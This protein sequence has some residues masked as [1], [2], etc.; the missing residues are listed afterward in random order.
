MAKW[1]RVF[2]FV[3]RV[4]WAMRRSRQK[5]L[6]DLVVGLL[7]T[8]AVGLAAI[9]RGMVDR[10]TVRHRVK[11]IGRFLS[12]EA[13]C[14]LE[15]SR[16]LIDVIVPAERENVI[17]V[18]WTDRGEYMLLKAS[19]VFRRRALPLVW[20]HV[21]KWVYEKSQNDVEEHLMLRLAHLVGPRPWVLVADRGFGRTELFRRLNDAGI[22]YV[23][24]AKDNVWMHHKR[25]EGRVW[26]M[27]RRP[28]MRAFYRGVAWRKK[29]PVT[30][31][32]AVVHEA[33]APAPWF[34]VTNLDRPAHRIGQLYAKRMGIEEGIRDAKSGLRL[35]DHWLSTPERMDRMMV[36]VA[37]AMLLIALTAAASLARGENRQVTTHKRAQRCASYF[38][39]GCRILETCP[40]DLCINLKVLHAV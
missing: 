29:Q 26:D 37:V 15:V 16:Y 18:D 10:T 6:A 38:T 34:L 35:K 19:L 24:R 1:R 8:Q 40:E 7:R 17:A 2:T 4:C 20:C 39:L 12:N 13:L 11:R 22:P 28:G 25:Y 3:G 36:L 9:A 14:P 5:T 23:I 31:N 21:W 30:V 32:L 27:P 33:E